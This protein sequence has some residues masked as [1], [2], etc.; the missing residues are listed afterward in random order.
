M[1]N[2]LPSSEEVVWA[3]EDSAHAC[4]SYM[5]WEILSPKGCCGA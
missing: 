4:T 1:R 2:D 5:L 3:G